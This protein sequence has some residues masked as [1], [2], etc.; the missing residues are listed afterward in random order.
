VEEMSMNP[1]TQSAV[2]DIHELR[3]YRA[4]KP[5]LETIRQKAAMFDDLFKHASALSSMLATFPSEHLGYFAEVYDCVKK[6]R[7]IK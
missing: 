3:E 4:I 5:E 7:A 6:A 2:N 1:E